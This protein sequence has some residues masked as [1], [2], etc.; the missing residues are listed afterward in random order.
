MA[1]NSFFNTFKTTPPII[2]PLFQGQQYADIEKKAQ[3]VQLRLKTYFL[4]SI[5][6]VNSCISQIPMRGEP[7][8][9]KLPLPYIYQKETTNQ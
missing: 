4:D 2:A 5:Y 1:T 8:Y 9:R 6:P 3:Q 7:L